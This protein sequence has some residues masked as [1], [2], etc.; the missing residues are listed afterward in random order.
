MSI[1]KIT[2]ES[3]FIT[4]PNPSGPPTK[5]PIADVLRAADIPAITYAQ[6]AAITTLANMFAIVIRTLVDRNILDEDFGE[7]D[8]DLSMGLD[9]MIEVITGMGGQYHD[10]DLD[11]IANP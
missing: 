10:P 8:G 2:L 6:V 5:F 1:G 3:G 11:D 4:I 9:T 7:K